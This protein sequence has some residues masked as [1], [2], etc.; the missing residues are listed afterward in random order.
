MKKAEG[1]EKGKCRKRHWQQKGKTQ[2][3]TRTTSQRR[4]KLVLNEFVE[5]KKK[6][7]KTSWNLN[8]AES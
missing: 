3:D 1:G 5:K 7:L 2:T 4:K 6:P 8:H